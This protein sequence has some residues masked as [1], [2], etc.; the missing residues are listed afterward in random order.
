M[1]A[2]ALPSR[3]A[4]RAPLRQPFDGSANMALFGFGKRH[5]HEPDKYIVPPEMWDDPDNAAFFKRIGAR[6]DDPDNLRVTH[7]D[8]QRMIEEGRKFVD[9]RIQYMKTKAAAEGH[10]DLHMAMFWLIQENCWNGE[11]GD[12]LIYQLRLNPYEAWN[13]VIT[14]DERTA[15]LLDIPLYPGG[16]IPH[17]AESGETII[18][19]LRDQLRAVMAEAERTGEFGRV[20]DAQDEAVA[21][22]KKLAHMFGEGL[23]DISRNMLRKRAEDKPTQR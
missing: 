14:G 18:L 21:K 8:V 5:K 10:R 6:P 16:P 11:V 2:P 3:N 12:F 19:Q 1:G 4:G 15:R 9:A 17:L 20:A 22:V 13:T 23:I 7:D